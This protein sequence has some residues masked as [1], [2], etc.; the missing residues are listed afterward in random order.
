ME[1]KG[2]QTSTALINLDTF[3][4]LLKPL[5]GEN[6]ERALALFHNYGP[7]LSFDV[8]NV[9]MQASSQGKDKVNTV[10]QRLEKHYEEHLCYQDPRI[11]GTIKD[12]LLGVNPTEAEFLRICEDVLALKPNINS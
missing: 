9:L 12:N 6:Y 11:R 10:M 8:T 3:R 5:L 7:N 4:D 2:E 1:R